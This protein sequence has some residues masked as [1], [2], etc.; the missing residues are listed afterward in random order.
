MFSTKNSIPAMPP[1]WYIAHP[2]E[3]YLSGYNAYLGDIGHVS[4]EK[5]QAH[6]YYLPTDAAKLIPRLH[7]YFQCLITSTN[8]HQERMRRK[9]YLSAFD[10]AVGVLQRIDLI[11]SS[12]ATIMIGS[13][14]I[15]PMAWCV[16]GPEP[17]C[18][19]YQYNFS[20][21]YALIEHYTRPYNEP[22]HCQAISVY[23]QCGGRENLRKVSDKAPDSAKLSPNKVMTAAIRFLADLLK[24]GGPDC[25]EFFDLYTNDMTIPPTE[26]DV[27]LWLQCRD[28][29]LFGRGT[30]PAV[31]AAK[32]SNNPMFV[33]PPAVRTAPP[34]PRPMKIVITITEEGVDDLLTAGV[35]STK[36]LSIMP[37]EKEFYGCGYHC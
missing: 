17:P 5:F 16:I 10:T 35:K 37:E 4:G 21:V 23:H 15:C 24:Y 32:T 22:C 7:D 9:S 2:Y 29:A 26:V 25:T 18:Q 27:D 12:G 19:F 11:N 1:Y 34:P 3:A 14:H 31:V 33:R 36:F 13:R 6:N 28:K 30:R 20:D 8:I